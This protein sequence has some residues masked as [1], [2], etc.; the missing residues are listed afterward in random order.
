VNA[1]LHGWTR[2][3]GVAAAALLYAI[4][5]HLSNSNPR[6][7][8]LGVVLALAPLLIAVLVLL[9]RCGQRVAALLTALLAGATMARYWPLL[10]AHFPWL[11][12]TQQAG[13]YALL[14]VLFGRS[15][16]DGREPLCT[17]WATMV[18]GPLSPALSRYT[19]Q[20]TAAWTMFF[21]LLTLAQVALF[22]LAPLPV[23]SAFANFLC[24]PL[25]AAMFI[26]E[27]LVRGQLLPKLERAS[28]FDGVRAF[29]GSY[30]PG[31]VRRG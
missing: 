31:V 15:L 19:R 12:L 14:G 24:L 10:I 21:A 16:L 28:I 18:H 2:G 8:V 20:V 27:Y 11:Y 22:L 17:H 6:A 5:A 13:F 4:L 7:Q 1:Q 29:L 9:W 23:W 25:V 30:N 3:L 26:G